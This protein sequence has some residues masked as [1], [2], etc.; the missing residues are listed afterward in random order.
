MI[1]VKAASFAEI[2]ANRPVNI[3]NSTHAK[4][5]VI[6]SPDVIKVDTIYNSVTRHILTQRG[7]DA[8]GDQDIAHRNNGEKYFRDSEKVS[9]VNRFPS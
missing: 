4:V 6:N 8:A 9:A 1:W 5:H 3:W 2:T 7:N